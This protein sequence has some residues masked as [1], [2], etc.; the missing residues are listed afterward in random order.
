MDTDPTPQ[1]DPREEKKK[2]EEE[3]RRREEQAK[4]DALPAEKK[5]VAIAISQIAVL[6]L[7]VIDCCI[8]I[9]AFG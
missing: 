6:S 8:S 3:E 9:C 5:E 2:R 1:V 4:Y 7:E